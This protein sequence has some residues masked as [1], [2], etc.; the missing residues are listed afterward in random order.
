MADCPKIRIYN[1]NKRTRKIK[2]FLM[3]PDMNIF[4]NIAKQ[5]PQVWRLFSMVSRSFAEVFNRTSFDARFPGVWSL[6][7]CHRFKSNRNVFCMCQ[8][9][10]R[11]V[12]GAD[13]DTLYLN[14]SYTDI[15]RIPF[16]NGPRDVLIGPDNRVVVPTIED[17][18]AFVSKVNAHT[19]R[20]RQSQKY[21]QKQLQNFNKHRNVQGRPQ[22]FNKRR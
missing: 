4:I 8:E 19:Q 5:D 22:N 17:A 21:E 20:Q 2:G 15:H 7:M 18:S 11:Y 3:L 12:Y 14:R 16:Y 9:Y 6:N 10:A 1:K 13:P